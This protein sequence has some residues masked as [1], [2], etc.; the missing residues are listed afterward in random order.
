MIEE[1]YGHV[2]T[3]R[4]RKEPGTFHLLAAR[5]IGPILLSLML[6]YWEI[7]CIFLLHT[8]PTCTASTGNICVQT[9]I[10]SASLTATLNNSFPA[11]PSLCGG[12]AQWESAD[13]IWRGVAVRTAEQASF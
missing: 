12:S 6:I 11:A 3:Q 7:F 8:T 1:L 9:G 10:Y 2:D 4:G 5:V 13:S